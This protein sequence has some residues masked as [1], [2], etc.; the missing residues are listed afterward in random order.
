MKAE[1]VVV[2]LLTFPKLIFAEKH[3]RRRTRDDRRR[4][5]LLESSDPLCGPNLLSECRVAPVR[6]GLCEERFE[7]FRSTVRTVPPAKSLGGTSAEQSWYD[8]FSRHELS[9]EKCSETFPAIFEPLFC[10]SKKSG[11][12]PAKFPTTF[13]S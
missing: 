9:H 10:G 1:V 7:R 13:V 6:F 4:L 2:A 12:I 8:L 3:R 11:K 5:Q